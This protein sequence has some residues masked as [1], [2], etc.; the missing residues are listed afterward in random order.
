M[1]SVEYLAGFIDGEGSLSLSRIPRGQVSHEY[2]VRVTIANTNKAILMEVQRDW[3]G[4]IH[5]MGE[6]RRPEWKPGFVLVWTNAAAAR[7]LDRVGPHLWLKSQHVVVLLEFVEHLR[8]CPRRRDKLGRL[9]SFSRQ[10]VAIRETFFMRLKR[11]NRKGVAGPAQ[12]R[13][14][15]LDYAQIRRK[16]GGMSPRYLAGFMDGEGSLMITRSRS[17]KSG[18]VQYRARLCVTNTDRG[19]LE[20]IC[21]GYGGTIHESGRARSNWKPGYQLVWT[22]GLIANLLSLVGPHLRI[23]RQQAAVQLE[24]IRHKMNTPHNFDGR[25]VT[26][27]P[28][29]VVQFR[30][31]LYQQMKG[32]N[33][34]GV[35][36]S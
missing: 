6:P 2:C 33:A 8:S 13:Y 10:E 22:D 30:E 12:R 5:S 26:R 4:T 7:L 15:K 25:V 34:R 9:L 36:L 21:R 31:D 17:R 14:Q 16:E 20:Q 23:K 35:A 27:H 28:P 29:E 32:L 1:V 11:L 18:N 19:I 24:F 3:G